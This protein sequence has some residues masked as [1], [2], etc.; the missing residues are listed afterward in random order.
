MKF[1]LSL[2]VFA[3]DVLIVGVEADGWAEGLGCLDEG[4][5]RVDQLLFG[6]EGLEEVVDAVGA[7]VRVGLHGEPAVDCFVCCAGTVCLDGD[8]GAGDAACGSFRDHFLDKKDFF[9]ENSWK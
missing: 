1:S 4:L 2:S 9:V 8:V 7:G 6:A 5:S 3:G